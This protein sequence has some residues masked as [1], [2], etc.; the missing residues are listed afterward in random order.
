MQTTTVW[1]LRTNNF[2]IQFIFIDHIIQV[3]DLTKNKQHL[4]DGT[5]VE[6]YNNSS[7]FYNHFNI[8]DFIPRNAQVFSYV[9]LIYFSSIII[10]INVYLLILIYFFLFISYNS[11]T[12]LP[13]LVLLEAIFVLSTLLLQSILFTC[14][15]WCTCSRYKV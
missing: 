10:F 12:L 9:L 4:K 7:N 15:V 2:I 14:K 13:F 1:N 8:L 11:W 3:S 6:R 5:L